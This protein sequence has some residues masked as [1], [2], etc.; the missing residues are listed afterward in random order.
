MLL[1]R[2]GILGALMVVAGCAPVKHDPVVVP[3]AVISRAQ[4]HYP[5]LA[6]QQ[7]HEG[8]AVALVL[9][10][11][12]GQ[13]LDIRIEKSSGYLE[14]DTAAIA[15][16]RGWTFKPKTVDGVPTAS[17]LKIPINFDFGAQRK[18][19]QMNACVGGGAPISACAARAMPPTA[20]LRKG[21][22]AYQRG[23]FATALVNFK[24]L[25]AEGNIAAQY[26]LGLMYLRGNGTTPNYTQ[27]VN[28]FSKAAAAGNMEAESNLGYL[29]LRG[30]GV[31]RDYSMALLWLS[32]ASAQGSPS[33]ESNLGMLY[34]HGL[35][36]PVDDAQAFH[37]FGLAAAQGSPYAEADLAGVYRESNAIPKDLVAAYALYDDAIRQTGVQSPNAASLR[38]NRGLAGQQMTAAQ[39]ASALALS[40]LIQQVG[41]QTAL[42]VMNSGSTASGSGA[43]MPGSTDPGCRKA[44]VNYALQEIDRANGNGNAAPDNLQST[45]LAAV[46]RAVTQQWLLPLH[47]PATTCVVHIWQ[48]RGGDVLEAKADSACPYDAAAKLSVENAVL[49]AKRLPYRGFESLFQ[50]HF[51]L[52]FVPLQ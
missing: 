11:T 35:G 34:R 41:T 50:R 46:R 12:K 9:V 7:A 38:Y 13:P 33:A 40:R 48:L 21:E 32:K 19:I 30:V 16:L 6:I 18:Q 36:V 49:R 45:Y 39:V 2:M 5:I 51:D 14:L 20:D 8:I 52:T 47:I 25:A 43:C 4:L 31:G 10:G 23:D 37:W 26:D 22:A 27:A 28:W 24:Q 44:R 29:Y 42:Q 3:V 1:R 17:Y 15:S